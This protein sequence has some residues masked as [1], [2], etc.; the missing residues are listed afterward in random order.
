MARSIAFYRDALGFDLRST[1]GDPPSY[2]ILAAG[3]VSLHLAL[4]HDGAAGKMSAY[5]YVRGVDQ[6]F[7]RCRAAGAVLDSDLV[8]RDYGMKDFVVHDPDE[9]HI[10]VGENASEQ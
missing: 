9:N 3:Q 7:E 4:D 5:I 10:L 1:F 2:A 8:V 6:L